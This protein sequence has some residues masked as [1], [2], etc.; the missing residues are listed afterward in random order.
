MYYMAMNKLHALIRS[1][2]YASYQ[3]FFFF[4]QSTVVCRATKLLF[5]SLMVPNLISINI[6]NREKGNALTCERLTQ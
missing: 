6:A 1:A 2:C 5:V 3:C 4:T